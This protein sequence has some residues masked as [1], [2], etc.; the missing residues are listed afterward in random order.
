MDQRRSTESVKRQDVL[1]HV[2]F[3]LQVLLKGLD[4]LFPSLD[5]T[6]IE[7]FTYF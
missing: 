7:T 5:L 1:Q 3:A 2:Q 4:S 6:F